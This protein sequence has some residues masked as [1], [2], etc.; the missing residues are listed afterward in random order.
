MSAV[1]FGFSRSFRALSTNSWPSGSFW[2]GILILRKTLK[3]RRWAKFGGSGRPGSPCAR[4]RS[5]GRR[6]SHSARCRRGRGRSGEIRGRLRARSRG[7]RLWSGF[8]WRFE[9]SLCGCEEWPGKVDLTD[10]VDLEWKCPE[11]ASFRFPRLLRLL[12]RFCARFGAGGSDGGF[13]AGLRLFRF[14]NVETGRP[15]TGV[16]GSAGK[17]PEFASR[18]CAGPGERARGLRSVRTG[19]GR[20]AFGDYF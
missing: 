11:S 15:S 16:G 2:A 10:L 6:R 4:G 17:R 13:S 3:V 19:V 1:L 8:L 9:K 7:G 18:A 5:G 12:A 14:L 20:R